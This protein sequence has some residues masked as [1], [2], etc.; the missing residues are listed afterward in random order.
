VAIAGAA[1]LLGAVSLDGTAR[2]LRIIADSNF[3]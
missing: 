2:A 1:A 3:R